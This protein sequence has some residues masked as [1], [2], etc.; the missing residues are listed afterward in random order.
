[1]PAN[2][3]ETPTA[4]RALWWALRGIQEKNERG[5]HIQDATIYLEREIKM[6]LSHDHTKTYGP[7]GTK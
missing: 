2:A 5:F 1:M 3:H 7:R 6:I 4:H